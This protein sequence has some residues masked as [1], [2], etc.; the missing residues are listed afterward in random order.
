LEL[1][2]ADSGER[3]QSSLGTGAVGAM[4][5]LPYNICFHY[6]LVPLIAIDLRL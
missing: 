3:E 6:I 2:A 4:A 5:S 1:K